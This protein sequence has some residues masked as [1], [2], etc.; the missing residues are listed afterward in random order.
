MVNTRRE[1]LN[2]FRATLERYPGVIAENA[3][4][5]FMKPTSSTIPCV[6]STRAIADAQSCD[7]GQWGR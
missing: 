5:R 4:T 3:E 6:S 2:A 7:F 1:R